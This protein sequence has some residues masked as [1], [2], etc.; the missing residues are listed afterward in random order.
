M[1]KKALVGGQSPPQ[2]LEVSP[3]GGLYLL[4]YFI[5]RYKAFLRIN[6]NNEKKNRTQN[7]IVV[8]Q[9]EGYILDVHFLKNFVHSD[10]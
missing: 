5:T 1:A 8:F 6:V 3:R 7:V 9:G 2:E 10:G 4:E